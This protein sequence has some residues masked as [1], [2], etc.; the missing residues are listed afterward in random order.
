MRLLRWGGLA[1]LGGLVAIGLANGIVY[2]IGRSHVV[3]PSAAYEA[4]AILVL[5]ALVRPD[6][7]P[8]DMLRWRLDEAYRLYA[9]HKAPKLLVTGD[10]GRISY[11]EVNAMRQ[12]LEAKGVPTADIF[13]DHAGFDTYNSMYRARDVFQVHSVIVVTQPFHLTRAV[14]I[15]KSLGLDVQGVES[16]QYRYPG[17]RYYQLREVAARPKAL[18]EVLINKRPRFLGPS[19]PIS[20]DGRQTHDQPT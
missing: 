6:A 7:T 9:A 3:A 10:H 19:I 20:G 16:D 17:Q 15:A 2:G 8:S 12:Y 18:L 5:G 13:M 4:Q 1:V 11:D 14:F